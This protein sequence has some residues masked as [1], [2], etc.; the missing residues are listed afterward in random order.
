MGWTCGCYEGV[1]GQ[2]RKAQVVICPTCIDGP[3]AVLLP[4]G[5]C[6][7]NKPRK[8]TKVVLSASEFIRTSQTITRST[9]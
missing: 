6:G 7:R 2:K 8:E 9:E 3:E 5:A 1:T 4:M